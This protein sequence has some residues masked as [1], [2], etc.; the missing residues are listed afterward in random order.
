[1]P[2][3]YVSVICRPGDDTLLDALCKMFDDIGMLDADGEVRPC[4]DGPPE[5]HVSAEI[6][7]GCHMKSNQPRMRELVTKTV[8]QHGDPDCMSIAI[9]CRSIDYDN[10][11]SD[12]EVVWRVPPFAEVAAIRKKVEQRMMAKYL[13]AAEKAQRLVRLDRLEDAV[14]HL[15]A[16]IKLGEQWQLLHLEWFGEPLDQMS[17]NMLDLETL[18]IS[19]VGQ[20]ENLS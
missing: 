10:P 19:W 17:K 8:L 2:T 18:R 13:T 4:T 5:L 12:M 3:Y 11:D 6:P 15:D 9:E 7:E 1:M 20:R 16:M 14:V